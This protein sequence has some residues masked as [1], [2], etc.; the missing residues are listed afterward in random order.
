LGERIG[1]YL[2]EERIGA[3]GMAEVYRARVQ[4]P[5]G[6]EK[7]V[8]VK[9]VLPLFNDDQDFVRMFVNEARVAARLQ[10]AN[11]VQIFDF[12]QDRGRYYIAMEYVAGKDLRVA[13]KA[14]GVPPAAPGMPVALA[15]FVAGEVLRALHYAQHTSAL[16]HRDISPHN[17]L[18]GFSG[19]V[20][21][22][23]FGIA[24][25]QAAASATRTGAIKG[26]LAYMAPEQVDASEVDGRTDLFAL[27]IVLFE[28]LAGRRPFSGASDAELVARVLAAQ[29]PPLQP[30]RPEVGDDVAAVV[31]RLLRRDPAARFQTPLEALTALTACG[32]YRADPMGLGTWLQELFP[33]DAEDQRAHATR[34]E[35]GGRT[36]PSVESATSLALAET[37]TSDGSPTVPSRR[38]RGRRRAWIGAAPLLAGVLALGALALRR[39]P[40]PRKAPAPSVQAATPVPVPA[41]VPPPAPTPTVVI[42]PPPVQPPED[43]PSASTTRKHTRAPHGKVGRLD[44]GVSPWAYIRV[45]GKLHG[46]SPKTIEL[47]AGS[48]RLDLKFPDGKHRL[49]PVTIRAGETTRIR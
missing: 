9:R 43:V 10:H 38:R 20:K 47:P 39:A 11:I 15:L 23:D 41:P 3:G 26:K 42:A 49:E 31:E 48:Y 5:E 19:D 40:E 17:V 25:A 33:G 29:A 18:L 14:A 45:N 36:G 7:V 2:L 30:L 34:S 12:D 22:G 8:A 6:F 46:A 27:G 16:V 28:M 1:K 37:R 35:T 44:V 24:K 32:A 13:L 21:L 4:G